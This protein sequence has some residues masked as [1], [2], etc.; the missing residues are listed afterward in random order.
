[1]PVRNVVSSGG[2]SVTV[3]GG[4]L[5]L[6]D[7]SPGGV[8]GSTGS[9]STAWQSDTSAV[10][11]VGGGMGGTMSVMMTA[12]VAIGSMTEVVSYGDA[13]VTSVEASP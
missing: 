4:G 6:V 12:G 10:C 2:T 11:L 8:V 3:I 9:E 7:S 1:M 5:G 13:A